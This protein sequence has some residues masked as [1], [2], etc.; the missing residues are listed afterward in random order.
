MLTDGLSAH[1][2]FRRDRD[3]WMFVEERA[4]FQDRKSILQRMQRDGALGKSVGTWNVAYQEDI[5]KR[6]LLVL[7][8]I[9]LAFGSDRKSVPE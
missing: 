3:T 9:L 5:S 4:Y 8:G 1:Y 7:K 6:D 2:L